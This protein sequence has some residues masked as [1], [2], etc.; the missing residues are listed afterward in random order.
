MT[1]TVTCDGCGES[2]GNPAVHWAANESHRPEITDTQMEILRGV[3]MGDGTVDKAS[4]NPSVTVKMITKDYLQYL[5]TIFG[6]LS[7]GVNLVATAAEHAAEM[8]DSGFRPDA[9]E[10][11]YSDVYKWSTR[12]HP[13]LSELTNWYSSGTKVF[14]KDIELTPNVLTNWYVCDGH[15]AN[16]GTKDYITIS[17][18]NEREDKEKIESMFERSGLPLPSRWSSGKD[19]FYAAWDKSGTDTLFEY[20]NGPINGFEYKF[21]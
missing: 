19:V 10:E 2:Y 5:D 12:C 7:R 16:D 18:V 20:M 17:M 13:Q 1:R 11:N 4:V 14:P 9:D 6:D 8:R 21:R 15:W 3:V